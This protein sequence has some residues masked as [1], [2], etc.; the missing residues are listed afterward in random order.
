MC[1]ETTPEE[2]LEEYKGKPESE[3]QDEGEDLV[4]VE[5]A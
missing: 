3:N 2:I 5:E 4:K 1:E